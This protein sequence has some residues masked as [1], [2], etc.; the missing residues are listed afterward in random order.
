VQN[1]KQQ[2]AQDKRSTVVIYVCKLV[3]WEM[4][5]DNA[6]GGVQYLV[7]EVLHLYCK[8]RGPIGPVIASL[9]KQS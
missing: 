9:V 4:S 5:S 7:V 6:T 8:T 1:P 2:T 3:I